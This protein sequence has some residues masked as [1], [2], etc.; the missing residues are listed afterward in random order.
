MAL[1]GLGEDTGGSIRVPSSFCGLA[2]IRCTPGLI[3]R[4]GLSPLLV[5]QDTPGP[6]CRTVTDVAVTL[7]AI[8]GFD[9]HDLYTATAVIAGKPVGGSYAANF[10]PDKIKKATIGVLRGVFG[11]DS[12]PECASVNKVIN[13]TLTQLQD[14]GTTFVDVEIPNLKHYLQL[15]FTYQSRSRFD[16]DSFFSKHPFLQTNTK[17]IYE[18]KQYH[19]T[20]DIF[21]NMATGIKHPRED[22]EFVDRLFARDEL[23]RLV[24]ATIAS[25]GLDALAFPSVR[26]PA[27]TTKDLLANRWKGD[28]FPTNTL[29][30]SQ[31]LLPAVSVP[32]GLTEPG[33]L[34][35]GLEL[36]GI[37]YREQSLLELAFGV[38]QLTLARRPP[39]L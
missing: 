13:R 7:D 8:V 37:P 26:I 3:S 16:L 19:P 15:T 9:P 32:A 21:E 34:P 25:R 5:P 4:K 22:P 24:I 38:E 11:P 17:Q 10:S 27:P 33:R 18:N 35:V 23:Q 36:L 28:G 14:A 31:A 12:D 20:L 30:A 6:M 39:S 29:I 2:G 1:I